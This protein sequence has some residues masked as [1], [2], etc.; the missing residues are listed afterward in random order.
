MFS[1]GQYRSIEKGYEK[2]SENLISSNLKD[3][4]FKNNF[5]FI[6]DHFQVIK[7]GKNKVSKGGGGTRILVVRPLKNFFMCV[8]P[9]K[10]IPRYFSY[11]KLSYNVCV[12]VHTMYM[13]LT[14]TYAVN[15][16]KPY[17]SVKPWRFSRCV[18]FPR[19]S[20]QLE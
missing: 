5:L 4:F 3:D 9:K 20:G 15:S 10:E 7:K 14:F 8:F 16:V 6:L 17:R 18:F 12:Y 11:L 19:Q 13:Y 1:A 2:L